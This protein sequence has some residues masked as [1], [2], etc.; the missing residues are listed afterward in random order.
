MDNLL[1][2]IELQDQIRKATTVPYFLRKFAVDTC[3]SGSRIICNPP[4]MDTDFD[5][6]VLLK[7]ADDV[8]YIEDEGYVYTDP[9]KSKPGDMVYDASTT[10]C[11]GSN[12]H[13]LKTYR[14]DDVNLICLI[15]PVRF[16]RWRLATNLCKLLNI[17]DRQTRI[18]IFALIKEHQE[19]EPLPTMPSACKLAALDIWP[20]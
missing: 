14:K 10:T 16:G 4:V 5:V 19:Y 13:W 3:R 9:N 15:D 6:V 1:R 2:E 20:V 17:K 7:S 12:E 11:E 18:D 8:V